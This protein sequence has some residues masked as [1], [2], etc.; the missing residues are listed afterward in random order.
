MGVNIAVICAC[1][2]VTKLVD[3]AFQDCRMLA[4]SQYSL[5]L[6]GYDK[7]LNLRA[8]SLKVCC[9]IKLQFNRKRKFDTYY[10]TYEVVQK[11]CKS[12]D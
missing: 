11:V 12:L 4:C 9:Q 5:K 7:G 1:Q 10:V 2:C 8:N 6:V 3:L